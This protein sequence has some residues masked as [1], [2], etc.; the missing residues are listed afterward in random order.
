[1]LDPQ[2]ELVSHLRR[3][4]REPDTSA[5]V[6][7]TTSTLFPQA[8]S[9]IFLFGG[10]PAPVC[11]MGGWPVDV[12]TFQMIALQ[13]PQVPNPPPPPPWRPKAF[14]ITPTP[15]L[16]PHTLSYHQE[17]P[18][19]P[20]VIDGD[21]APLQ[22]ALLELVCGTPFMRQH[23]P[24]R[25]P[26]WYLA[27]KDTPGPRVRAMRERTFLHA[28]W[29]HRIDLVVVFGL[30]LCDGVVMFKVMNNLMSSFMQPHLLD[31]NPDWYLAKRDTPGPRVRE[32]TLLSPR[33]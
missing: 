4:A 5:Y 17:Y 26:D 1:V 31:R 16:T 9:R 24:D 8:R 10:A 25:T 12:I 15:P 23:L 30:R 27:K 7:A 32:M 18:E 13:C 3:L 22:R 6:R 14:T 33:G 29:K 2:G 21:G 11:S 19:P 28:G 20:A